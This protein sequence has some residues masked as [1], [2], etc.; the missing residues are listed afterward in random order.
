M[1]R[2]YGSDSV[3]YVTFWFEKWGFPLGGSLDLSEI[4]KLEQKLLSEQKKLEKNIHKSLQAFEYQQKVFLLWKSEAMF[5]GRMANQKGNKKRD[6]SGVMT[7]HSANELLS[8]ERN[9][10]GNNSASL[11]TVPASVIP[12]VFPAS[13]VKTKVT[14]S[15]PTVADQRVVIY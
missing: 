13:D 6:T 1:R 14:P 3:Q 5:R 4:E 8:S 12:S 15:S 10:K 2:K 11:S 9:E 7:R